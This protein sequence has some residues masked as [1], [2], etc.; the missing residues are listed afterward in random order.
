LALAL[1]LKRVC[2]LARHFS[3]INQS[4]SVMLGPLLPRFSALAVRL[5]KA[6]GLVGA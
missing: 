3:R 1:S 4:G 2:R 6:L 5:S